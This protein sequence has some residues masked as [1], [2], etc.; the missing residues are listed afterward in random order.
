VPFSLLPA[1]D[2]THGR[3]GV[4]TPEGP[5]PLAAFEGDALAAAAMLRDAGARWLHVVD[6]D[7][8]FTGE[9]GG[10][11]TVRAIAAL[12]GIRVQASGGV[13][14]GAQIEALREAGAARVVLSSGA[15]GDEPAVEDLLASARPGELV[16]GIEVAD[17][18]VRSR[19]IGSVDLDLMSTLGWLRRAGAA[20]FLVTAVE[21]VGTV[22]GPDVDVIRRVARRG[23]E[24]LAAGGIASIEDLRS[25]REAGAV[26]AVI[27]RAALEG[28]IDLRAAFAWAAL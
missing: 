10:I 8:A 25:V 24:T 5:V 21:R 1:I 14:T 12:E 7:L 17:G 3:L 27:G 26:G 22:A 28:R 20:S 9:T 16:V 4:F 6:M 2:L 13:R 18:R 19:G 23:V 11:E 15:L